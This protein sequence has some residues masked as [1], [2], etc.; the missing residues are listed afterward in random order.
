MKL[1]VWDGA[2]RVPHGDSA[3]VVVAES[4]EDARQRALAMAP[5][6]TKLGAPSRIFSLPC[7]TVFEWC[8]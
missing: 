3:I 8:E 5:R 7:A 1:Y 2:Y 6:D 4:E